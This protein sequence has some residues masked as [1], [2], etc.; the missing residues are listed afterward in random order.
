MKLRTTI[1]FLVFLSDKIFKVT[2]VNRTCRSL[3]AESLKIPSSLPSRKIHHSW[4]SKSF[5]VFKRSTKFLSHL[6]FLEKYICYAEWEL[7]N[8]QIKFVILI[9]IALTR[10]TKHYFKKITQTRIYETFLNNVSC[11]KRKY[12]NL[13]S[14]VGCS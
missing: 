10:Q 11:Y 2:T 1:F 9:Y 8:L 7:F 3:T 6:E 13:F 12:P 5:S 14:D 4:K